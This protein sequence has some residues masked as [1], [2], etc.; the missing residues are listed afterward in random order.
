[1]RDAL[2]VRGRKRIGNLDG[3]A[4]GPIERERAIQLRSLN[5][6][7][8]QII[9]ANIVELA[10]V[11]M[12]QRGDRSGLALEPVAVFDIKGFDGDGAS[13]ANVDGFVNLAHASSANRRKDFVRAQ[14]FASGEGHI[15][16]S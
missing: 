5:E 11:G 7:H 14:P 13:Q 2:G 8:H 15:R 4:A 6:F 16:F 3:V 10:N 1:M 9:R 12:I